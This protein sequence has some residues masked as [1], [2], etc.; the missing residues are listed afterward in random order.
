MI[1]EFLMK[2][3]C[4]SHLR[5]LT[6][7]GGISN[8]TCTD[9]HAGNRTLHYVMFKGGEKSSGIN[10]NEVQCCECKQLIKDNQ[11][12]LQVCYLCLL[13]KVNIVFYLYRFNKIKQV[14]PIL[15]SGRI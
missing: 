10:E 11:K 7:N 8:T 4:D 12:L 6:Y 5:G 13:C 9:C 15:F 14:C 3:C 2:I 1:H